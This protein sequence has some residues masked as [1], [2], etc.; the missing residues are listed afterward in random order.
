ML[1]KLPQLNCHNG[2]VHTLHQTPAVKRGSK[3]LSLA[4]LDTEEYQHV[5][6]V[7]VEVAHGTR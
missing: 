1:K 4:V 3:A 6:D 5:V 7:E 2:V